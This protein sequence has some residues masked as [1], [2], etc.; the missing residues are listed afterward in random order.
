MTEPAK[1]RSC[2]KPI[3]WAKTVTGASIPLD[4]DPE[5]RLVFK[6]ASLKV[7]MVDTYQTHFATCKDADKWRKM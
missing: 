6:K 7:E 4:A 2:G 1:C 5:K 3:I